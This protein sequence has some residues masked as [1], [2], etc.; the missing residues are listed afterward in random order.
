MVAAPQHLL[1]LGRRKVPNETSLK[2]DD[3]LSV[4]MCHIAQ[5]SF[6]FCLRGCVKKIEE[7]EEKSIIGLSNC[8]FNFT[9]HCGHKKTRKR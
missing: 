6:S 3:F 8:S 2:F 7:T 4:L 9:T 1:H 5:T